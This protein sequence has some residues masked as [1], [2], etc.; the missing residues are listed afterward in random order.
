VTGPADRQ[1]RFN[2][3]RF[4]IDDQ[5]VY[6]AYIAGR[7]SAAIAAA[8]R[9][10]LFDL[11]AGGAASFEQIQTEMG[12]SRRGTRSMLDALTAMGFV[13]IAADGFSASADAAAYLTRSAEGSLWGLVDMEVDSFLSPAALLEALAK[14]KATVYGGEDPWA[15]HG[16]DPE[17]ARAFTAAMHS[18]SERPAAGVAERLDLSAS[19]RLLDVGGGSGA[20]S[21]A[22]ARANPEL[23][24]VIW[25]IPAVCPI[26]DEYVR[27]AG[28]EGRVTSQAGDMF[29]DD[30]PAGFDTILLSQILHDWS[31]ETG[32]ELVAKAFA[33]LPSGGR[34]V[35]HEKL[36]EDDDSG[37]LANQL[38]HLDMLVWTE[39][40]QYRV[41]EL[42]EL[43]ERSGFAGVER[44]RTAGY[45]SV[46][47]GLK[48]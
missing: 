30:Y 43:L 4:P 38:V 18:V 17:K 2:P 24:C 7:K 3:E 11:L 31:F 6:D 5:R 41:N 32:A 25:D 47:H 20:L 40:Q 26:A 33:A 34:L 36:V 37:P 46:V 28:C 10:G 19:R 35:I 48:P 21:I 39:G 27:A 12:W 15:A 14:D 16:T 44:L 45:W 29:A 1:G 9:A 42:T 13:V 22:L 8:V 23:E